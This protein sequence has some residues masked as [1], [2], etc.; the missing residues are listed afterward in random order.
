MRVKNHQMPPTIRVDRALGM[1]SEPG[2]RKVAGVN[3]TLYFI[4]AS[5]HYDSNLVFNCLLWSYKEKNKMKLVPSKNK[6]KNKF[7]FR[8]LSLSFQLRQVC[9]SLRDEITWE[10]SQNKM[11]AG[12]QTSEIILS[13][14]QVSALNNAGDT[15]KCYLKC[16]PRTGGLHKSIK[17]GKHIQYR[18]FRTVWRSD[19]LFGPESHVPKVTSH[20]DSTPHWSPGADVPRARGEDTGYNSA[21]ITVIKSRF[22]DC[23]IF[24]KISVVLLSM[25]DSYTF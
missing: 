6:T 13:Q 17:S 20:P 10:G 19:R 21:I 9:H 5:P 14:S 1:S 2:V 22:R 7:L 11:I 18:S 3:V 25:G 16:S 15:E 23:I 24:F 4:S 12:F 8:E